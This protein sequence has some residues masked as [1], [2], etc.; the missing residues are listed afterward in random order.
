[1]DRQDAKGAKMS[2][3]EREPFDPFRSRGAHGDAEPSAELDALAFNVIGAAIEV[4]R[5]LGPGFNEKPYE[6][7]LAI[8]LGL[9]V[10][11]CEQQRPIHVVYQ[12]HDVGEGAID[13]IVE[14][15]LIVELKTVDELVSKHSAQVISYLKATNLPLGLLMNFKVAHLK[16]GI[17]RIVLSK[18]L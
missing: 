10:I 1:M 7:A 16:D 15:K 2:E 18:P 5:E 8:E 3:S 9:R 11:R 17:Q 4:H 12:G 6:N 13:R 14:D